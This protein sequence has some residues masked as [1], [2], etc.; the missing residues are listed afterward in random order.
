MLTTLLLMSLLGGEK[1]TY[2]AGYI[3]NVQFAP[4]YVA[5]QKGYY[6]DV[7]LDVVFDYTMGAEIVKLTALGKVQIASAD[8]DAFLNAKVR[9]LPLVHVATLYQ[10][11]PLG[12]IA[13]KD[14][15]SPQGLK[16]KRIGVSGAFGSS[17]LGL[18]MMLDEMGLELSDVRMMTI[19]FTQV[20]ALRKGS[21]DAV[22]GY[23]NNEPVRLNALDVK[24]FVRTPGAASAMPG[25][26]LMTS[27]RFMKE[28]PE[29]VNGFLTATFRGLHDVL[30]DPRGSYALVVE[31]YLPELKG[32]ERY[33][34]E[35]KI[36]EATL[37]YWR[38]AYTDANGYGQSAEQ[39]WNALADKLASDQAND[40]FKSWLQWVNRDFTWKPE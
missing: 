17:Y 4:F 6:K 24:T 30:E 36:L 18:K 3:P 1:L 7:G 37:P 29:R 31:H 34:S 8:P 40:K 38:N 39:P 20:A 25:V 10:R 23:I 11:Y 32:K 13:S 12:L 16:G 27:N 2:A 14:I 5:Q 15:L 19:G 22:M 35:Y 26:G 33:E 21:V 28:H 9:N